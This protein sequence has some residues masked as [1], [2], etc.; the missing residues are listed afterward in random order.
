MSVGAL[1]G[2]RLFVIPESRDR[3]TLARLAFWHVAGAV[4]GLGFIT[5]GAGG[6]LAIAPT[7][8][9]VVLAAAFV[10]G[11]GLAVWLRE[12]RDELEVA[13]ADGAVLVCDLTLL[14]ASGSVATESPFALLVLPLVVAARFRRRAVVVTAAVLAVAASLR[15]AL[16]IGLT[17]SPP[18]LPI[19]VQLLAFG[20]AMAAM[21]Q[22]LSSQLDHRREVAEAEARRARLHEA[23]TTAL[24]RITLA[25]VGGTVR[26]SIRGALLEAHH[27][28]PG[29]AWAFIGAGEMDVVAV[30]PLGDETTLRRSVRGVLDGQGTEMLVRSHGPS[31]PLTARL[32]VPVEGRGGLLGALVFQ[33][34]APVDGEATIDEEL[35][36]AVAGL[37]AVLVEAAVAYEREAELVE[38]YRALDQL[39]TDFVSLTSHELRTPA[40]IIQGF[41]ETLVERPLDDPSAVRPMAEAIV[42]HA[43]RLG[44]VVDDLRTISTLDAGRLAVETR[45]FDLAE[46]IGSLL[47]GASGDGFVVSGPRGLRVVS[48]PERLSQVVAAL[49]ENAR[50]HGAGPVELSWCTSG[51]RVQIDVVDS[52]P[53]IPAELHES[54]FERFRTGG[55]LLSH[56]RGTGLGLPIARD[57]ARLLGGDV[58]LVPSSAGTHVRVTLPQT[59]F[60]GPT[61]A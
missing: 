60:L 43:R 24:H 20:V 21:M 51:D 58:A 5:W 2:T 30:G 36:A 46:V 9:L 45:P 48:D 15:H 6:Q 25:G 23:R 19:T 59:C 22:Q 47:D 16:L 56:G 33:P 61:W 53:G 50:V 10:L 14:T 54:V 40:T 52:G 26:E 34:G 29:S 12:P 49:V 38:R 32:A 27:R 17:G 3:E 35:V 18:E 31:E 28:L 55:D 37:L 1:H 44:R 41:A 42:R 39:R 7:I 8:H 11:V 13:R 4:V 57:V